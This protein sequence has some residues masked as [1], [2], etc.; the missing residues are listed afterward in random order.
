[1]QP[2]YPRSRTGLGGAVPSGPRLLPRET[3][4]NAE[5]GPGVPET[6]SISLP[7]T[8]PLPSTPALPPD[9]PPLRYNQTALLSPLLMPGQTHRKCEGVLESYAGTQNPGLWLRLRPAGV[10]L[11]LITSMCLFQTVTLVPF[12][13]LQTT[14]GHEGSKA[15]I[16]PW[17][18]H[19]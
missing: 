18:V 14:G 4:T 16:T 5:S 17:P 10:A 12:G 13:K 3:L 2:G 15:P 6:V 9:S 8:E 1:M 11:L 19:F 7:V